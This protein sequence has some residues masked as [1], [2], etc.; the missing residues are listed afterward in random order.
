[1]STARIELSF[2]K[3]EMLAGEEPEFMIEILEMIVDESPEVRAKM[4]AQFTASQHQ[5]L[6]STAHKFKSSVNVLGHPVMDQL[7]KDIENTASGRLPSESEN[8]S[9]LM[10]QFQQACDVILDQIQLKLQEL[11]A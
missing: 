6:A 5:E 7:L 8:L 2:E 9:D 3:L 11:K 10:N 4:D 1:M